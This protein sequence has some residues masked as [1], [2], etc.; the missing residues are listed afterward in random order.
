MTGKTP[1]GRRLT[2]VAGVDIVVTISGKQHTEVVVEQALELGLPVLPIPDA[3]GDSSELLDKH[4]ERVAAAFDSGAL[5][6]CLGTLSRTIRN[7]PESGAAAVVELIR[8]A[9]FGKCLVLLPYDEPHNELYTTIIKPSI[10]KHMIPIR[11]D[12]LPTSEAIYT[13]F[14]D[15]V[16]AASA[17]LADI[18]LLNENV[19]YEVGYAHGLGLTPLI[20]TR[21]PARLN[22][23]PVYFRTLN[24]RVAHL[25]SPLETLIDEYL[26]SL[27]TRRR[28]INLSAERHS[29]TTG[30]SKGR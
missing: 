13:S 27:K 28:S 12:Y 6:R 29:T 23:L 8:T 4:R 25:N 5:D 10:D 26:R 3:G 14:A 11:L 15:A 24:V 17:V 16:R 9:K 30:G 1:L 20:Y 7:D 19:M 2:M 21:E 22:Q 18:T